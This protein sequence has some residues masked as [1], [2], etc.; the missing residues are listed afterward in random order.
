LMNESKFNPLDIQFADQYLHPI[1]KI[2]PPE[3]WFRI[4]KECHFEFVSFLPDLLHTGTSL[5]KDYM[6]EISDSEI[7]NIIND[8]NIEERFSVLDLIFRPTMYMLKFK[9]ANQ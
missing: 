3:E 6:N 5:P 7:R 8:M 4:L 2:Y 9:P 1:V